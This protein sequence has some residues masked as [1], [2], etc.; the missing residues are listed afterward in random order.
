MSKSIPA[1]RDLTK[2]S[3]VG[4]VMRMAIPMVIGIGAIISFSIADMYFIGQLGATELAAISYTIPVT[5]FF[6]NLI[7]GLA[8]AMSAVVSRK[9]GAGLRDEVRLTATIGIS[10]AVILSSVLAITGYCFLEPIFRGLGAGGD[11]IP[12]IQEYMPVWLIGAIFLSI[13]VVANSAIRGTG[14]AIWPAIIMVMIA[15]INIVLDPILIFG[16]FGAPALGVKGAAVASLIAYI[17]AMVTALSILSFREKLFAPF[18]VFKKISW[19]LTSKAL[20]VIAIPVS[21]ANVVAPLMTYGYTAILSVV[22][23]EAVAA[24]GIASRFEAFALIPIMAVAGGIAP[25]IG[26]NYGA[27]LQSRVSEALGKALKFSV[28]YGVICA[29]L[30]YG[31]ASFVTSLFSENQD[32]QM[33]AS[34]YLMIVPISYVGLNIFA[35]VTSCMNAT[36]MPKQ[37]LVLNI[38][39]SFV[40]ALPLAY[41]LT[42]M[43]G[44]N[45]FVASVVITNIAAV[46]LCFSFIKR[47]RCT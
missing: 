3:I 28:I 20:L 46:I 38:L 42:D 6:F 41:I 4:H 31:T 12:Y 13:P 21:L 10:M 2:G 40:L 32:I 7:F 15:V 17:C 24:Y 29:V 44:M 26:Q 22:G 45:G 30:L 37:A 23:N 16:W 27:G 33:M 19:S 5:T 11:T 36:E 47:I 25:L 34:L 8:I 39:K 1:K 18:C 35:V 43:Y 9:I 14:D